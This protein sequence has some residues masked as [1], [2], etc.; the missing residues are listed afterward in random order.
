MHVIQ[1]QLTNYSY[2]A[3]VQKKIKLVRWWVL[4][5]GSASREKALPFTGE[6]EEIFMRFMDDHPENF[7]TVKRERFHSANLVPPELNNIDKETDPEKPCIL[8]IRNKPG[9]PPAEVCR[10]MDV[11]LQTNSLPIRLPFDIAGEIIL[12]SA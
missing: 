5:H 10:Q 7:P 11:V 3:L 2:S 9:E 8:L 12:E 4:E 6:Q 1:S